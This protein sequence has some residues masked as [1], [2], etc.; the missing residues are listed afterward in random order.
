MLTKQ[1]VQDLLNN[2]KN[3]YP[4]IYPVSPIKKPSAQILYFPIKK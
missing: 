2:L 1:E 3:K 4:T